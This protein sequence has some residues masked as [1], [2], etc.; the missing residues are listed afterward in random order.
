MEG[1]IRSSVLAMLNLR[2]YQTS[3]GDVMEAVGYVSLEFRTGVGV[4]GWRREEE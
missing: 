4:E 1:K 2:C 3:G